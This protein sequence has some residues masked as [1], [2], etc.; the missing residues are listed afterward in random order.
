LN[1]TPIGTFDPPDQTD[2]TDQ[3]DQTD[4]TD[5]TSSGEEQLK[6]AAVQLPVD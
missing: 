5:Q 6:R 1:S 4:Q 2:Q 3:P